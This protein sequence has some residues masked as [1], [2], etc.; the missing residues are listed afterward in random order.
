ME[1]FSICRSKIVYEILVTEV[2][3]IDFNT[4]NYYA[5]VHTA[6]QVWQMIEQLMSFDQMAQAIADLY[7]LNIG[8]AKMDLRRFIDQLL[9][10]G[11][12]EESHEKGSSTQVSSHG[13][14]Y[15]PP[16]VQVYT[17]VQNLLLLDPVHEV[18][19][20]GWPERG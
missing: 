1:C 7:V 5:L 18:T 4:G 11:L 6:K 14:A 13:W 3:A 2:I 12:I 15:D 19:E 16:K 10:H 9:E 17:D 8:Q 20:A